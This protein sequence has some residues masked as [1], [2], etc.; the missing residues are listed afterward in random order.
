MTNKI[1]LLETVMFWG[2]IAYIVICDVRALMLS[3]L[4]FLPFLLAE[5]SDKKVWMDYMIEVTLIAAW[6]FK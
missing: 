6:F 5:K 4:L 3:T 2:V 1:A